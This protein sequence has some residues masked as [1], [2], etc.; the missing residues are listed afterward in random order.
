LFVEAKATTEERLGEEYAGIHA[1][2][3]AAPLEE[4]LEEGNVL[5]G[6]GSS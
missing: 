3:V 6:T 2:A 1:A 5:V 4:A